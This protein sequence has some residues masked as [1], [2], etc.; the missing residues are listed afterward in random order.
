[1]LILF[2]VFAVMATGL[3]GAAFPQWFGTIGGS[4]YTLFQIMTLESWSMGIVR[5]VMAE[6]PYSWLFFI[7]FILIAT[8]T[9]LNLF[10]GI[11]VDTMQTMHQ[12]EA[13]EISETHREVMDIHKE[14]AAMREALDR[15]QQA[16]AVA[17]VAA[18]AEKPGSGR[19]PESSRSPP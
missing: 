19:G 12:S 16:H 3:F 11:I 4:M 2:Y 13:D 17:V 1:M 15:L 5:P 9:M 18:E 8:F 14:I 7:P 6:Y 10:I